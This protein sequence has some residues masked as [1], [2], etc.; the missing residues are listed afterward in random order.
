M[1]LQGILKKHLC[2][3]TAVFDRIFYHILATNFMEGVF[4]IA[5]HYVDPEWAGMMFRLLIKQHLYG[6][7]GL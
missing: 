1:M 6:T 5:R 2:L 3:K 4:E 7:A